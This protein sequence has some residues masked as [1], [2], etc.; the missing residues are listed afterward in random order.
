MTQSFGRVFGDESFEHATNQLD[1]SGTQAL[2]AST[3]FAA[4]WDDERE[5]ENHWIDIGGEG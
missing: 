1:A 5:W 4:W 3:E 2:S